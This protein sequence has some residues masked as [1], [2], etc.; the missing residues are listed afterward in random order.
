MRRR[1]PLHPPPRD[2]EALSSWVTRLAELYRM[3]VE[4]LLRH[5]LAP[6][7]TDP[8]LRKRGALDLDPPAAVLLALAERTGV[9]LGDVHRLTIAGQVPWLLDTLDPEPEPGAAFDTY[10][11]QDSVLLTTKERRRQRVPGWRAWVPT[12]EPL[13]RACPLCMAAAPVFTLVSQL[14][15]TLSCPKHGCTL[16]PTIGAAGT[17][18]AWQEANTQ[19]TAA[20]EAVIAMDRRTQQGLRTGTVTVPRR[21]VHVGVWFR[22][23]RTLIDELSTPV[24]T[25]RTRSR[26][27]LQ[28]IW[29]TT[30]Q[31]VRAGLV[32]RW[33]SYEALPWN[34]QQMFLEAAAT[35]LHL[36]QAGEVAAHGTLAPLLTPEPHRPVP[37]GTPP[38]PAPRD[39]WK[40]ARDA[41]NGSIALAQ[42]DP[43][44]GRQLLTIL[45]SMTRSEASFQRTRE[46][47]IALGIPGKHLPS[48]LAEVRARETQ[49]GRKTAVTFDRRSP[50]A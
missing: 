27:T 38:A 8:P 36:V 43:A 21:S 11:H 34:Q 24:S 28:Y 47:L 10:V 1:W 23:L 50:F 29:R 45:T 18:L 2:D 17:F 46:D 41:M 26:R 35:A 39:Y 6:P 33:C 16:V 14:P 40:E 7:G 13:R 4:E 20:P 30:G 37:D 5:D 31:P 3:E 9:P 44:A 32:G 15:L 48:T 42:D 19:A 22:L 49:T 25:L 12:A